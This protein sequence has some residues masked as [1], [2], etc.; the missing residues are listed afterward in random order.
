MADQKPPHCLVFALSCWVQG[1]DTEAVAK[2][3]RP[4]TREAV[5]SQPQTDNAPSIPTRPI[6]DRLVGNLHIGSFLLARAGFGEEATTPPPY[7]TAH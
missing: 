6:F 1:G 5:A 7:L 3:T 4:L 2:I